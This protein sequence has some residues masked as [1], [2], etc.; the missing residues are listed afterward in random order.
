[1]A[2]SEL[3]I[4]REKEIKR[5]IDANPDGGYALRILKAYREDCECHMTD[6][7]EGK[8]PTNLLCIEMNRVN[9]ERKAELDRAIHILKNE[10]DP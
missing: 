1:M 7:T 9:E 6:N 4:V 3:K 10:E 8:P 2:D 5:G